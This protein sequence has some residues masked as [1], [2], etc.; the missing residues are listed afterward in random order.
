MSFNFLHNDVISIISPHGDRTDNIKAN[1]QTDMV[2]SINAQ[3][4]NV[5]FNPIDSNI[6]NIINDN[7]NN[8]FENIRKALNDGISDVSYKSKVMDCLSNLEKSKG[9]NDFSTHYSSFIG[10]L[11]NC[12]TI[13]TPFLPALT[14]ML[15]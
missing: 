7:A 8:L 5:N 1:V 15:K 3:H 9:T 13:I 10:L 11:A 6:T 14:E 12:V 4:S 2:V